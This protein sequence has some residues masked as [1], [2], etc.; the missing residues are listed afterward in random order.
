M[1]PPCSYC[2]AAHH[3][4]RLARLFEGRW[5][6]PDEPE[7]RRYL[8]YH[9]MSLL[10]ALSPE[11]VICRFHAT[12][13]KHVLERLADLAE[14]KCGTPARDIL[15]AVIKREK[16]GS[17]GIGAGFAIPHALVNGITSDMVMI[18]TLAEPVTFDSHDQKP[19]D[20]ICM[21]L[22]PN[23]CTSSHVSTVAMASQLLKHSGADMRKAKTIDALLARIEMKTENSAA[24]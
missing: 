10:E 16:L 17:T 13:K 4:A 12:S 11:F 7:A 14:E 21:V 6:T 1:Q 2:A 15:D 22:G 3:K 8:R 9:S 24:A 19:V 20:V 18:A 5:L 23:G